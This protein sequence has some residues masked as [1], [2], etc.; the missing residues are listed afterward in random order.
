VGAN[1]CTRNLLEKYQNEIDRLAR[2]DYSTS[3]DE[4]PKGAVSFVLD[5]AIIAL[6]L[7]GILDVAAEKTRLQKEISRCEAEAAKING[8]LANP[9]FVERA[10]ENVIEEQKNRLA[11]YQNEQ[12]KYQNVLAKL[13]EI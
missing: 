8:K 9:Q 3:S 1:Q 4:M 13:D 6:P 7:T 11:D 12:L 5:E 10:P 2:L